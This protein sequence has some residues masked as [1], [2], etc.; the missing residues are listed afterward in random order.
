VITDIKPGTF[1]TV[2]DYLKHTVYTPGSVGV[3]SHIRP[4]QGP[5]WTLN[6]VM[7]RYGKKGMNRIERVSVCTPIFKSKNQDVI[8]HYN[9]GL[10]SIVH[11]APHTK[12]RDVV[13]DFTDMEF[14]VWANAYAWYLYH[15]SNLI[16]KVN[17]LSIKSKP[18]IRRA[19]NIN[20]TFDCKN[21]NISFYNYAD[22]RN[23]VETIRK[24][25]ITMMRHLYLYWFNIYAYAH[26]TLEGMHRNTDYSQQQEEWDMI[27]R[28][29]ALAVEKT[30][31]FAVY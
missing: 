27:K 11:V 6:A 31:N 14:L 4:G 5:V 26:D 19:S 13:H 2:T 1:F 21:P 8:D 9:N 23:F 7:M 25:E 15:L 20:T 10:R 17:Q 30:A 24:K 3:V 22:K 16:V 18:D 12:C 29:S 28:V